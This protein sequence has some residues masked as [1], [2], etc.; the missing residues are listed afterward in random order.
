M[1]S[2]VHAAQ[3]R[4]GRYRASKGTAGGAGACTLEGLGV[5]AAHRKRHRNRGRA[6]HLANAH[7]PSCVAAT[8]SSLWQGKNVEK[9]L[10]DRERTSGAG[11]AL[12]WEA[13]V[14]EPK[15]LGQALGSRHLMQVAE[16]KREES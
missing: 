7:G 4:A 5:Q 16:I 13:S 12:G 15:Q 2:E 1:C 8:R 3:V 6:D 14:L 11:E 10:G 9:A